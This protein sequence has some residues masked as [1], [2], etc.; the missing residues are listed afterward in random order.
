MAH[1][2]GAAICALVK[3][4]TLDQPSQRYQHCRQSQNYHCDKYHRVGWHGVPKTRSSRSTACS[5]QRQKKNTA[6]ASTFQREHENGDAAI[7]AFS[8]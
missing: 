5:A 4:T 6:I 1:K 2:I 7:C 8:V 3:Y